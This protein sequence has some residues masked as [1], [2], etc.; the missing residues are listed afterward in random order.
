[1]YLLISV[2]NGNLEDQNLV[3]DNYPAVTVFLVS[4]GYP[5]KYEKNQEIFG[6]QTVNNSI[7]FHAGAIKKDKKIVTYGGRV[8]AVTSSAETIELALQKSYNSIKKI[9]AL[10]IDIKKDRFLKMSWQHSGGGT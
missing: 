9:T 10:K 3:I 6:L 2:N 7:V 4:G 1:M 5:E 8:L